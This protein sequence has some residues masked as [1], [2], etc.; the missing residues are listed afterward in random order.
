MSSDFIANYIKLETSNIQNIKN[1]GKQESDKKDHNETVVIK[2]S[3]FDLHITLQEPHHQTLAERLFRD[4]ENG[5]LYVFGNEALK[6]PLVLR[7]FIRKMVGKP[8]SKL[9]KIFLWDLK[10]KFNPNNYIHPKFD[11]DLRDH[12]KR[13][14]H[15]MLINERSSIYYETSIRAISWVIYE[16]HHQLLHYITDRIIKEQN[17][18]MDLFKNSYNTCDQSYQDKAQSDTPNEIESLVDEW[19]PGEED[20]S[21][22][23]YKWCLFRLCCCSKSNNNINNASN[24]FMTPCTMEIVNEN[25]SKMGESEKTSS[26]GNDNMAACYSDFESVID[27]YCEPAVVEQYRLLCHG[28]Y[29]GDLNTVSI[30]LKHIDASVI[31]ITEE[32]H[33]RSYWVMDP[34]SI[35]CSLGYLEIAKKLISVGANVNQNADICSPLICAC[36]N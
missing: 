29:S 7:A 11:S 26:G 5:Y 2:M 22:S 13:M 10:E 4:V 25:V 31:N 16:G 33:K 21:E 9:H 30:L 19:V 24:N 18:T 35:A 15:G 28:C 36:E 32:C 1:K 8:Y 34:L 6:H 23:I 27:K 3:G 20:N 14:T 12:I 17:D